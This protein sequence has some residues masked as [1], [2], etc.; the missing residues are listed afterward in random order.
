MKQSRTSKKSR[1]SILIGVGF[2]ISVIAVFAIKLRRAARVRQWNHQTFALPSRTALVTGAS[3][4]IGEAYARKLAGMGFNLVLVARRE[5]RL[6][7]LAASLVDQYGVKT[8]VLVADL[9]TDE[10]IVRTEERITTR[11][12]IDFLVNNAGYDIFGPFSQKPIEQTLGL[13]N[14]HVLASIRFC[15]AALPGMLARRCG[16]II[17]VSSIGAFTPK[18]DDATYVAT[19]AYLNLF[20]ES[21]AA[22]LVNSG[23]RIQVLCP[24]FTHT[25]FHDAPEYEKYHI[26]ERIPHWLWMSAEQVVNSSLQALSENREVCVP[27]F[28][29]KLIT[30]FAKLGLT[31]TL[32]KILRSLLTRNKA[33]SSEL[34]NQDIYRIY[35]PIYD[36]IFKPLTLRPRKRAVQLLEIQPDERLLVPGVGTGL[37]LPIIPSGVKTVAADISSEMIDQAK[38]KIGG[39]QT[40][41]VIMD[42]QNSGFADRSFDAVLLNLVLSVV[43]DGQA[44][45]REA[46][47]VLRKGGRVTIFDKFLPEDSRLTFSRRL[48]G[49]LI[50]LFGTDPNRRLVDIIGETPDMVLVH[51]EPSLM[52]GRYQI[53]LLRKES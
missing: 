27:G 28:I 26:K 14:C 37:D 25:E 50:R 12:D 51:Q 1:R 23:V 44:A 18:P 41:L 42:A 21:L 31:S 34:P 2:A 43:P 36:L 48:L 52:H 5:N 13:I 32:L 9:S 33:S 40:S 45:F 3:S 19:K 11:D 49:R 17:N 10:G 15:R 35:A 29:N 4:G 22:E 16:A 7:Q 6:V 30:L 47:R 24:G 20:S 39:K 38:H 46:W 8:E 53:L